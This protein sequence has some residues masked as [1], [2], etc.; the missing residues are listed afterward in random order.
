MSST[1][2]REGRAALARVDRPSLVLALVLL[3]WGTVLAV[4]ASRIK[5]PPGAGTVGPAAFPWAVAVALLVLG[6]LLA[7][8]S[9][10]GRPDE[11]L[12][13]LHTRI[14][15]D[16]RDDELEDTA[17]AAP[18]ERPFLRGGPG[19]R[20]AVFAAGLLAHAALVTTAGYVVAA[21][22]LFV[23]V[24]LSFGAPRPWR[25]LAIGL[26]L[27]LVVFYTFT[28]ALGLALPNLGGR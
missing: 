7:A 12:D 21:L 6:A 9:L 11:A 28:M 8:F 24:A 14:D 23:A 18:E 3:A 2:A 15:E 20:I 25:V 1:E 5:T 19:V 26:V 10:R 27:T 4:D 22:V 13:P 16:L 17:A